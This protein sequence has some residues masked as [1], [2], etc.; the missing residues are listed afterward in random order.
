MARNGKGSYVALKAQYYLD[1]AI[2]E[3]GPEAELLWVRILSFLASVRTD[4]TLT[5]LQ[6]KSVG[7]GLRN[8]RRRVERLQEVGLLLHDGARYEARS[9]SKW[10]RSAQEIDN[11]LAA[12]RD[13]KARKRAENADNSGRNS[14]DFRTESALS[15]V[16]SSSVQKEVSKE[17]STRRARGSRISP[18][19]MPEADLIQTMRDECPQVNLEAEH[20]V[21][22]DYW[23]AQ[24]GQK[25]VKTDWPATWR[26]WM[27]RK[28]DERGGTSTAARATAGKPTAG[29]KAR[30]IADEFRKEGL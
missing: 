7:Y 2:L 24:P 28:Q 19:W 26:N 12:E 16:Q 1:D 10:N 5:E 11:Y 20:R 9:W 18:D 29:D 17:T 8:L 22:I 21:F 6:L 14:G 25:G 23:I 3:A 13:R 27:R 15:P 30:A 4:G